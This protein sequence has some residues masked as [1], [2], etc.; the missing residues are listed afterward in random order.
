VFL[1]FQNL[2]IVKEPFLRAHAQ[3]PLIQLCD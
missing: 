2:N 1:T 3:E